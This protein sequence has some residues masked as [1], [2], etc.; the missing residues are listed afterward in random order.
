MSTLAL[1]PEHAD[2]LAKLWREKEAEMGGQRPDGAGECRVLEA[3]EAEAVV[4][5][6]G[7]VDEDDEPLPA[8]AM[9]A[10]NE[11]LA[12]R[13]DQR[14]RRFLAALAVVYRPRD[15]V[16]RRAA[17]AVACVPIGTADKYIARL[18][19]EGAWPYRSGD[20][21]GAA[22]FRSGRRAT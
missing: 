14:R 13:A 21:V 12:R 10:H 16:S 17:A 8:W 9:N 19:V 11:A 15:M 6:P 5:L 1:T 18:K 4:V 22:A 20:C 7:V 2:E 3:R